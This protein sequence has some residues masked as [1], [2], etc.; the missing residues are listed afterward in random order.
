[1]SSYLTEKLKCPW[2]FVFDIVVDSNSTGFK[3]KGI[4]TRT[5]RCSAPIL[6]PQLIAASQQTAPTRRLPL[7]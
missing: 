6:R 4:Y 1:M 7:V 5:V 2:Q 3:R